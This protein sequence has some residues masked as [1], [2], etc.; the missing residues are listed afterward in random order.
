[1]NSKVTDP[2][3]LVYCR[4]PYVSISCSTTAGFPGYDDAFVLLFMAPLSSGVVLVRS[5]THIVLSASAFILYRLAK[6]SMV[7]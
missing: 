5:M 2:F 7:T 4:P 1:M 3:L 6:L